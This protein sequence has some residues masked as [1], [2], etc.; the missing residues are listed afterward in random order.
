MRGEIT[1]IKKNCIQYRIK[2]FIHIILLNFLVGFYGSK[3]TLNLK[4]T[5][6]KSKIWV[7]RLNRNIYLYQV[8][9]QL[10]RLFSLLL[11]ISVYTYEY[12]HTDTGG[13]MARHHPVN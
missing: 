1:F 5:K 7:L 8:S 13:W 9:D 4:Y 10:N 3:L 12:L 11:K 6:K 2:M